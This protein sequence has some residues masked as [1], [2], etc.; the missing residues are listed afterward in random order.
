MLI[1]EIIENDNTKMYDPETGRWHNIGPGALDRPSPEAEKAKKDAEKDLAYRIG[2][3]ISRFLK[4]DPDYDP[5]DQRDKEV[6]SF[7]PCT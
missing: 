4:R 6:K 7:K 1:E 5:Y 2:R 3:G